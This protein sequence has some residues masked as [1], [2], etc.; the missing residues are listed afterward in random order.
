MPGL[1][2]PAPE[3]A[4]L[5]TGASS[6]IGA[7][8]ARELARRGHNVI[9]VARRRER[10]EELATELRSQSGVRAEA[11]PCDLAD[12]EARGRLPEQI[13]ALGL[14]VDVLVNN[15]GFATTGPYYQS[16]LDRELQ[17]ARLLVEAVADL[18]RR[19]TPAMAE[20][21]SGAVLT[22][23]STAGLQPMPRM[24]GYGAAKAWARSFMAALHEELRH[25]G[26]AVT[27]LSPGPVETEL[28]EQQDRTP[29]EALVPRAIWSSSE[30]VARAGID[31]LAANRVEVIPGRAMAAFFNAS[32]LVPRAV[33]V[34]GFSKAARARGA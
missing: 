10:L 12:A 22:V 6:G 1:P 20:R 25:K 28:W 29:V 31:A 34:P 26:I 2:A 32:K 18:T 13:D 19:F 21:G 23:A 7:D 8:L 30:A 15:A 11:L 5:V 3:A 33:S 9:L 4:A 14:R 27:T 16:D 24:A 17:Q